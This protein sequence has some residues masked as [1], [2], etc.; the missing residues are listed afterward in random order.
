MTDRRWVVGETVSRVPPDYETARQLLNYGLRETGRH[1]L[2]PPPTGAPSPGLTPQ[3]AALAAAAAA[4][5][6]PA[7]RDAEWHR[8]QRVA[9]WGLS[10]KLETYMAITRRSFEPDGWAAFRDAPL[11]AAAAA[12]AA[13]GNVHALQ[14]GWGAAP[15]GWP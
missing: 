8:I 2:P 13:A 5:P 12:L 11:A 6:W 15:L 4:A 10:D 9:L 1:G 14:V 3:P 7:G